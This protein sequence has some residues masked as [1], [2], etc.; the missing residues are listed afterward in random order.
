MSI[1]RQALVHQIFFCSNRTNLKERYANSVLALNATTGKLL[2]SF[3]TTHHDLWDMD[4]PSQPSLG[5]YQ[6]PNGQKVPAIYV[7]TKTGNFFVLNRETGEPLV[8]V[9]ERPVPQTVA[10]DPQTFGEHY[11]ATQPFTEINLAPPGKLTDT[12]M[13]GQ[14][15]SSS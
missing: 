14:L 5:D 2:W 8:L 4:V 9:E 13:W 10:H 11:S 3:Q 7:L 15:C 6:L 1:F 12:D